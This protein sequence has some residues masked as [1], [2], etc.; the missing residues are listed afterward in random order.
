MATGMQHGVGHEL[1]RHEHRVADHPVS[2]SAVGQ[3]VAD[4]RRGHLVAREVEPEI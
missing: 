3:R 2:I 4:R 1:A